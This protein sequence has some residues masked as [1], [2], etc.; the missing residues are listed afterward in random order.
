MLTRNI[1]IGIIQHPIGVVA[2]PDDQPPAGKDMLGHGLGVGGGFDDQPYIHAAPLSA[3][4][5]TGSLF[6]RV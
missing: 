4:T 6:I 3:L 5:A 2:A 1:H